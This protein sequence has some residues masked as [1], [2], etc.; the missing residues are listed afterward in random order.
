MRRANK[1]LQL[2]KR[3]AASWKDLFRRAD[4]FEKYDDFIQLQIAGKE[5]FFVW[6]GFVESKIGK[7]A[8]MMEATSGGELRLRL[9]PQ[10]F[11]VQDDGWSCSVAYYFGLKSKGKSTI[12]VATWNGQLQSLVVSF[13]HYDPNNCCAALS[14][15]SKSDL[16]FK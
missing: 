1:T 6:K 5:E 8:K 2:V 13:E 7:L 9:W 14:I 4:V 11:A 16:T 10:S 15:V 3:K 12:D